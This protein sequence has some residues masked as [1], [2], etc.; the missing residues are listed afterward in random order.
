M[1]SD[2]EVTCTYTT[3]H[4]RLTGLDVSSELAAVTD[5]IGVQ[6]LAHVC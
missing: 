6:V 4:E 5:S 2:P 1:N 3:S